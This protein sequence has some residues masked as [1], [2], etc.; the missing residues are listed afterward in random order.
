MDHYSFVGGV[1]IFGTCR[2]FF[3]KSNAFQTIF[4]H[5]ILEPFFKTLT[6]FFYRS[7]LKKKTLLVHAY[8]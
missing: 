1:T 4:F 6:G 5:Y 2:Q 7:Y 3:F 8:T